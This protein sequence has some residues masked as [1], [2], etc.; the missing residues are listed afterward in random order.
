MESKLKII[1]KKLLV[2]MVS[3]LM[4]LGMTPVTRQA[5]AETQHD[6]VIT[7]VKLTKED[8]TTPV[9]SI[10]YGQQMQFVAKFSLPNNKVHTGDKTVIPVPKELEI[11]KKETF[12]VKNA[13]G[14]T[15]PMR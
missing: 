9:G 3:C 6:D 12:P 5:F 4:L 2:V 11:Y 14:D 1:G 10:G 8:L 13:N 15:I 7:D